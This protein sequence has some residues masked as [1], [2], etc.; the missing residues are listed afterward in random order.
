MAL[1]HVASTALA[2]RRLG[3]AMEAATALCDACHEKCYEVYWKVC[4]E[5]V[6]SAVV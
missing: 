2:E 1:L 4:F 3:E 6:L 5:G